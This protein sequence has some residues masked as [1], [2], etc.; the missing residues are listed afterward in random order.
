MLAHSGRLNIELVVTI[1]AVAAIIGDNTGYLI[2]RTGG[3]RL[4]E[5]PGFAQYYRHQILEKGERF[6]DRHGSK[7]V[8]LGRWVAGVRI[9]AAWLAGANRMP[10]PTFLFW[11]ALGGVAWA[12]NVG[13]AAYLLGPVVGGGPANTRRGC[14]YRGRVP[15]GGRGRLA[16]AQ[17][18]GCPR[19]AIAS[20][21]RE[22]RRTSVTT[23]SP[24]TLL[25]LSGPGPRST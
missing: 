13:A 25:A 9:T 14:R 3:R 2:G 6:F 12:V 5:R 7:V 11:N 20:D 19:R 10:W 16:L 8:F 24:T 15:R 22:T 1:A 17:P 23:W 18:Q 4:L 21:R